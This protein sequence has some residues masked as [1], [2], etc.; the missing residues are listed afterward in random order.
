ML[1]NQ[2][3]KLSDGG[4]M[5]AYLPQGLLASVSEST[6]LLYSKHEIIFQ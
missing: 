4:I 2:F 1:K 5:E 3:P 6:Y